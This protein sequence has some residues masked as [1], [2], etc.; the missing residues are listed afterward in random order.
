MGFLQEW[1]PGAFSFRTWADAEVERLI[2]Q[3]DELKT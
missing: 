3:V 1:F 2:A